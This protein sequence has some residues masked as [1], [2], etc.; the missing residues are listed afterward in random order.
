M[1]LAFPAA[2]GYKT[3]M[4]SKKITVMQKLLKANDAIADGI[5]AGTQG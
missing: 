2:M 5:R 4:E 1:A 3:A